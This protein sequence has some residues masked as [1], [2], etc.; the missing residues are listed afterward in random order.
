[1]ASSVLAEVPTTETSGT[2][3]LGIPPK[4][5]PAAQ[6]SFSIWHFG[7]C[8]V[9]FG[10][11]CS[12]LSQQIS[13]SRPKEYI[14]SKLSYGDRLPCG[15]PTNRTWPRPP[16]PP[17]WKEFGPRTPR[18]AGGCFFAGGSSRNGMRTSGL[19]AAAEE[20][21]S[22]VSG[23]QS[24]NSMFPRAEQSPH[25]SLFQN[26]LGNF[27]DPSPS[28]RRRHSVVIMSPPIFQKLAGEGVECVPEC[29]GS[30]AKDGA[31]R[32]LMHP[33]I[34][35]P[36]GP[37]PVK[38]SVTSPRHSWLPIYRTSA[39]CTFYKQRSAV[40]PFFPGSH[41]QGSPSSGSLVV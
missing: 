23:H 38:K 17:S 18:M 41:L 1:M 15:H 11:R 25:S 3:E 31:A 12:A 16:R 36:L 4:C 8:H 24:F 30:S 29:H 7:I 28:V 13:G 10:Q 40:A 9:N 33:S 22:V 20:H 6:C 26:P 39:R 21:V 32:P 37:A 35:L 14:V 19:A 2:T 27:E 5:L 34:T